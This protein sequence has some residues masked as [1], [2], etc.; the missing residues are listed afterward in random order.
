MAHD[1]N[2]DFDEPGNHIGDGAPSFQLHGCGAALLHQAPGIP[3]LESRCEQVWE[4]RELNIVFVNKD[5]EVIDKIP[6]TLDAPA[7]HNTGKGTRPW[8]RRG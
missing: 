1:G 3:H 8:R 7:S 4:K 6:I 5:L 2:S